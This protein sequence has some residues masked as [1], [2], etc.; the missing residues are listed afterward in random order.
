MRYFFILLTTICILGLPFAANIYG[1]DSADAIQDSKSGS[2][3]TG[4]HPETAIPSGDKN[5]IENETDDA[6]FSD[7]PKSFVIPKGVCETKE[8]VMII[9]R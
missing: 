5:T 4:E 1:G 9:N 8:P 6:N 2:V 3:I 7:Y